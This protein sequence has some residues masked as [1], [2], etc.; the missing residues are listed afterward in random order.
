MLYQVCRYFADLIRSEAYL[1]YKIEVVQNGIVDGDSTTLLVSE[2]RQ[3]SSNFSNAIFDHATP[4]AHP[5]Y[6]HQFRDLRWNYSTHAGGSA[7]A[8]YYAFV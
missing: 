4:D 6:T 2:R 7:S 8:L 1:Q 3:Y 5:D